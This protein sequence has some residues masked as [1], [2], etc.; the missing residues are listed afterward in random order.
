MSASQ[1]YSY[2]AVA[3]LAAGYWAW[4]NRAALRAYLLREQPLPSEEAAD[5]RWVHTL[6]RLKADMESQGKAE[7]AAMVLEILWRVMGGKA[8]K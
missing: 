5:E 3:A 1:L 2:L 6:L 4:A 7:I 8:H